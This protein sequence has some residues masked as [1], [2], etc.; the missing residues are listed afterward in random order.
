MANQMTHTHEC[1]ACR[2]DDACASPECRALLRR[3]C[4][5]CMG[6]AWLHVRK[7]ARGARKS[8]SRLKAA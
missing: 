2:K 7:N 8:V 3:L 5:R 6:R 1:P 4:E